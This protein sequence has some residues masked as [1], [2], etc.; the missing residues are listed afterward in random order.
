MKK[1]KIKLI[2]SLISISE[3]QQATI[4]GLGLRKVNS[5]SIL[6]STPEVEGMVRK[7]SHLVKVIDAA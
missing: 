5:V 3:K 7:V 4:S 6:V 1:I 2:K